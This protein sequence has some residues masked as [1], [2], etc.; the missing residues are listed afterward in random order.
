[1]NQL[2]T[3]LLAFDVEPNSNRV[4]L[5]PA[6]DFRAKDGRPA[7]IDSW[8]INGAIAQNL[9]N[10]IHRQQDDVLIDYEHQ[11]LETAK[12]GKPSPAAGWFKHLQWVEGKGLFALGVEWTENAKNYI[13]NK[14]YRYIS[15]VFTYNNQ[16]GEI[17]SLKMAALVN[18]PAVDGMVS[19]GELTAA[20][21]GTDQA[22][23]LTAQ[24]IEVC[25]KMGVDVNEYVKTRNSDT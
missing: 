22:H 13:K 14:E 4:Q 11:T 20:K 2:A 23:G 18:Y 17:T 19:V 7:G 12:N 15:P 24:E 16:S 9:I 8:K 5:L 10:E 3:A 1:M 6:N 21:N 25:T